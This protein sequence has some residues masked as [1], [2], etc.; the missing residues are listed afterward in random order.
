MPSAHGSFQSYESVGA[1]RHYLT[2]FGSNASA[3]D[4]RAA[5]S[6][7]AGGIASQRQL[8]TLRP[9]RLAKVPPSDRPTGGA[10]APSPFALE[11]T[12]EEAAGESEYPASAWWLRGRGPQQQALLYPLHEV[13]DESYSVYFDL[14]VE[15]R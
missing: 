14:A 11:S 9:L 4:A 10:Q 12:F 2:T 6:F 7:T 15:P 13:V 5:E 1:P 8:G 3:L